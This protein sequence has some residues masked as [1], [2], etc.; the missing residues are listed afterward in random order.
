MIRMII[1]V[2]GACHIG[3]L[4]IGTRGWLSIA[5]VIAGRS[6]CASVVMLCDEMDVENDE[7]RCS[8]CGVSRCYDAI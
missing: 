3:V 4:I 1:V 2:L 8:A 6:A 5:G 7:A